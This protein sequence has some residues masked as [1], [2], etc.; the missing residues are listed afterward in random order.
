MT[1]PKTN[2]K[3]QCCSPAHPSLHAW[4]VMV[5]GFLHLSGLDALGTSPAKLPLVPHV[6][7]RKTGM[8]M[9]CAMPC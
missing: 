4:S 1:C 3:P 6:G 5:L 2:W 7:P 8:N 9:V